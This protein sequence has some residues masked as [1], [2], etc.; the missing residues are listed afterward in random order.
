M[1]NGHIKRQEAMFEIPVGTMMCWATPSKR[2]E[3]VSALKVAACE[4]LW[5]ALCSLRRASA[6]EGVGERRCTAGGWVSSGRGRVGGDRRLAAAAAI[7]GTWWVRCGDG[8]V[9]VGAV[10]VGADTMVVAFVAVSGSMGVKQKLIVA[11]RRWTS[12]AFVYRG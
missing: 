1:P 4:N 3:Q 10:I 5:Q 7:G 8:V 9:D 12:R 11:G 6:D 2:G